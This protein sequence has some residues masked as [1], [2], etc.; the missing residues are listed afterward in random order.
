[1]A[2]PQQAGFIHQQQQQQ[3]QGQCMTPTPQPASHAPQT[4]PHPGEQAT[5]TSLSSTSAA[6]PGSQAAL[7]DGAGKPV[8]GGAGAEGCSVGAAPP[9]VVAQKQTQQSGSAIGG[10]TANGHLHMASQPYRAELTNGGAVLVP[11][12]SI[13]AS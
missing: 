13:R 3:R 11:L 8:T 6:R 4:T 2:H 10:R 9:A 12:P 1:V 5:G 7:C